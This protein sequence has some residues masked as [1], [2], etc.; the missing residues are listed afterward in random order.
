MQTRKFSIKRSGKI[1]NIKVILNFPAL[2]FLILKIKEREFQKYFCH[3]LPYFYTYPAL[4]YVLPILQQ[5]NTI[6][7]FHNPQNPEQLRH[8]F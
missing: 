3:S 7:Y 6:Y 5:Q 8:I 4:K 1:Q 2:D